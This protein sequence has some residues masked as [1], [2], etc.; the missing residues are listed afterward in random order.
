MNAAYSPGLEGIVA[1][2]TAIS[3]V[4]KENLGLTYRGY[5]IGD[6]AEQATFEEVAYLLLHGALPDAGE[7]AR[8]RKRLAALR[9]L[10]DGLKTV[11]EQLP[12]KAHPMDV[13]R[14]GCS[15]LGTME[16]E[17][18]EHGEH[19]VADRLLAAFPGMLL[20]WHHFH[21]DGRRIATETDEESQAGHFLRL[22]HGAAPEELTRRAVDVSLILYA[23]HEFNASTFSARVTASTLADFYAAVTSAI[24]TL[25]GPLHG[26]ANEEA[27]KLISRFASPDEAE[28]GIRA[29]LARKEKIM[30]FGHRVYK[31]SL[32]PRS[33]IIQGWSRRLAEAAGDLTLYRV[34][35]R[36]E[37]L[38]RREKGL[39]PNLDFYSASAYHLCGIPTAMFT[40]VFVF[41]RIAGWSAHIIEQRAANRIF[42]PVAAYTGPAPR[43][44]V[45]F[46]ER[47]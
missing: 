41:A 26:G 6:L 14:T 18:A 8:Y 40:P 29:M 32:D 34:S 12:A 39:F 46:A 22:L 23:E 38:I 45:P 17:T 28:E 21:A 10:P 31:A 1:G 5:A 3:T 25:R 16:P 20:Y 15:A 11:L 27:M 35:E 4:G 44:Y 2:E 19:Q 43:K 36:I 33:P 13:L 30:G 37:A 9:G 7:L 24:G 47:G 42:R